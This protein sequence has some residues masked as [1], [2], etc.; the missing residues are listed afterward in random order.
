MF[1]LVSL[2]HML[3]YQLVAFPAAEEI[4]IAGA[5]VKYIIVCI[6]SDSEL[7]LIPYQ[8]MIAFTYV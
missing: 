6:Y 5:D 8:Y 7:L 1:M 3:R 2:T 4:S